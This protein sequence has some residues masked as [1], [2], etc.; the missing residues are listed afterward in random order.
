M[1]CCDSRSDKTASDD[2]S[3]GKSTFMVELSE[4]S[5]ILKTVTPRTL[6][7]LDE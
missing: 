5:E 2:L 3:R 1:R 6:V 4:T 7:I